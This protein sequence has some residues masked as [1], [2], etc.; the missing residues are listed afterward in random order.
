[1]AAVRTPD[2]HQDTRVLCSHTHKP[3]HTS[4]TQVR[5]TG[6]LGV[7]GVLICLFALLPLGS[8]PTRSAV[9]ISYT[10]TTG[11][12]AKIKEGKEA[13]QDLRYKLK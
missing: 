9:Q 10:Q 4:E 7:G 1:M 6:S 12:I 5:G 3:K 11:N 13:N 2:F 8:H